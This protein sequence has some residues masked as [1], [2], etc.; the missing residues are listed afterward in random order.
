MDITMENYITHFIQYMHYMYF[1]N[2][3]LDN[4]R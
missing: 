2:K 1:F 4:I 3:I